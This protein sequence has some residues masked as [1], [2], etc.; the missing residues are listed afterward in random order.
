MIKEKIKTLKSYQLTSASIFWYLC[1]LV[2][3]IC[4]TWLLIIEINIEAA[5]MIQ[6]S[7][8]KMFE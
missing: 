6:R 2:M 5:I 3:G 7:I 1:G 8:Y 4:G